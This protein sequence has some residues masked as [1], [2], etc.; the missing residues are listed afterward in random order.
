[1]E[2]APTLGVTEMFNAIPTQLVNVEPGKV[3]S[4]KGGTAQVESESY[5]ILTEPMTDANCI[6]VSLQSGPNGTMTDHALNI[7]NARQLFGDLLGSLTAIGDPLGIM[8]TA[9][10]RQHTPHPP[11]E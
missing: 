7:S 11:S 6:V 3:C 2:L 9:F 8:L 5:R 1:M 4:T 10:L